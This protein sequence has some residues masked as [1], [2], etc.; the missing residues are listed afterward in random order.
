MRHLAPTL[1]VLTSLIATTLPA[2]ADGPF[3]SVMTGAT[4]QDNVTNAPAGDGVRGDFSLQEG[5]DLS[6]L[7]SVDFSTILTTTLSTDMDVSTQYEG[8]DNLAI[9]PRF[10]LSHKF[11][12]GPFAPAVYIGLKGSAVGFNDP[13]RSNIEGGFTF[14][15]HKRLAEDIELTLDGRL[16]TCDARDIVFTGSYAALDS[17]VKWDV[18]DTWRLKLGLGWR[19]GDGVASYTATQSPYGWIPV[20]GDALNLPGAWHYVATFHQPFVAYK[21][22]ERTWT[23]GIGVSPAI[24]AHTA[25]SLDYARCESRAGASYAD[26]LV[27]LGLVHHF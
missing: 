11:G 8:L 27:S 26:D 10:E 13:E 22:S 15:F 21:V 9:G 24:G 1:A 25:L 3:E 12:V 4:W 18:D 23:Y 16:E 2:L 20:D 17:A 7:T 19:S 14:G 5:L 6:W